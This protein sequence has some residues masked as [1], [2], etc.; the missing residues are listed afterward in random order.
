MILRRM[1]AAV[2]AILFV[3]G[4]P[5]DGAQV[6]EPKPKKEPKPAKQPKEVK[7][8]QEP[9]GESLCPATI[10]VEQRIT[11]PPEGWEASQS[12]A[13]P[14]LAFVTF[15]DGPPAERASL[16]YDREEKQKRDWVAIWTLAPNTRGYWVQ[17][18]YDNTTGVLSRRLPAEVTSCK[19]TYERNTQAASGLPTVKHVGC[20]DAVAKKDDEKK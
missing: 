3:W 12:V 4:V 10:G 11:A 13:K 14:Q 20:S 17:C 1:I 5:A 6:R 18:G 15:F 16:K 9:L 7:P 2:V 8:K 19:V